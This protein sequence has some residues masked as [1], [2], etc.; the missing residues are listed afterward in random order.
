MRE[1]SSTLWSVRFVKF[2]DSCYQPR[3]L[4]EH[5]RSVIG[6]SVMSLA[7]IV[8]LSSGLVVLSFLFMPLFVEGFPPLLNLMSAVCWL[9]TLKVFYDNLDSKYKTNWKYFWRDGRTLSAGKE[10]NHFLAWIRAIHNK[11]CVPV[12]IIEKSN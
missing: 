5:Y 11:V 1:L 4:C 6:F 2:W 9:L 10:P 12:R 7:A 3:D 8:M